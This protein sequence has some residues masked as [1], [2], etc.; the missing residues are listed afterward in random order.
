MIFVKVVGRPGLFGLGFARARH[1]HLV[2]TP[3]PAARCRQNQEGSQ[4][5]NFGTLPET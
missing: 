4:V 3:Y 5:L 2:P 1:L